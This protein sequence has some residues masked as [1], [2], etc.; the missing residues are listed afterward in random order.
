MYKRESV[1]VIGAGASSEFGMPVGSQLTEQIQASSRLRFYRYPSQ[2]E[3]PEAIKRYIRRTFDLSSTEHFPAAKALIEAFNQINHGVLSAESIDEYIYRYSND[4][5]IAEAGKLLIA[6]LISI[7]ESGS[8]LSEEHRFHEDSGFRKLDKTWIWPFAKSLVMG[9]K[10]NEINTI[11][12]GVTIICFNYDR[13]VEHYLEHFLV[14][15]YHGLEQEQ[16]RSI[17]SQINIIHPYGLLG[18]LN[19][20]PYGQTD[21][22]HKM[23]NNLITWSE[24]G[25]DEEELEEKQSSI[26]RAILS[27]RQIVFLGF[28]FAAQNMR[29]LNTKPTENNYNTPT[30]YS[31]GYGIARE[32][33]QSYCE[34]II[35]C[36]SKGIMQSEANKVHFQLGEKC[37][38]FF[39]INRA[40]LVR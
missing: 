3:G 8:L 4:A 33:E 21:N 14:R 34:R 36:Y 1:F 9:V 15:T 7:A 26:R 31:S 38:K 23:A 2:D 39:E 19:E 12:Q 17:V 29:L 28:G 37:A 27:A 13:C 40:N 6:H 24:T 35:A 30:V 10:A 22:F 25:A 16:A 11:G 18:D 32:E 20:F 5:Q